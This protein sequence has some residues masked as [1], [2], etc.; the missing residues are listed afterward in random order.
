[1]QTA[2]PVDDYQCKLKKE[3]EFL[4][5]KFS[6]KPLGEHLWKFMRLRPSNFPTIRIA[7]FSVLIHHSSFLFSKI[8]KTKDPG[9]IKD[10]F[11]VTASGYWDEHYRFGKKSTK[12]EKMIGE[13]GINSI[14]INTVVPFLFLYGKSKGIDDL[15]ERAIDILESLPSENNSI[16]IKWGKLGIKA[17]NA[18]DS[19]A[20]LQLK[21]VYCNQKKCLNCQIGNQLIFRNLNEE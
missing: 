13:T 5:K 12:R 7:Q 9:I 6:L 11:R 19:Q 2:F 18:F 20:L 16:I 4:R 10:L 15:S 3:Y 14:L 21:N 17:E 8:I 1:M